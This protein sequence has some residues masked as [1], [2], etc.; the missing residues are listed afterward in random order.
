MRQA[1][2]LIE[3]LVVISIIAILAAMLLPAVGLVRD[4][5]RGAK[6]SSNLRQIGM[7]FQVYADEQGGVFPLFNLG[8]ANAQIP[9]K[10]YTNLLEDAGAIEDVSWHNAYW[11]D[12]RSGIWK[13]PTV[14]AGGMQNGGGYGVLEVT[15]G[16]YYQGSPLNRSRVKSSSTSALVT[17]AEIVSGGVAKSNVGFWCPI[18]SGSGVWEAAVTNR[19]AARHGNR[20]SA[21]VVFM[22]GHVESKPY[23][24][25]RSNIHDVWRCLNH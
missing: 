1:F 19:V 13:C 18:C 22:D 23:V 5:A 17:E 7:S 10:Y 21:N 25:L 11:G 24:D 9:Y 15:H 20:R 2:T 14:A 8:P 12:V 4:A 16:I 3:L 6:C